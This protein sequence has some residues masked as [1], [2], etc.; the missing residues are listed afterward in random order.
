MSEQPNPEQPDNEQRTVTMTVDADKCIGS[1]YCEML[2][3]D[4]FYVDDDTALASVKDTGQVPLERAE[5]VV[6]RCPA[7]AIGYQ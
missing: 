6:D 4:T 3:A 7:G 2:E 5:V 1:G